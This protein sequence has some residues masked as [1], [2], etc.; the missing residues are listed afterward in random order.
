MKLQHDFDRITSLLGG[1]CLGL[2][3]VVAIELS[4]PH[5]TSDAAV[6]TEAAT[7][8]TQINSLSAYV[9]PTIETFAEVLDRPL[10][11]EGRQLPPEP[12]QQAA[13]EVPLEPLKLTLEGV[14]LTGSSRV[15]LLRDQRDNAMVQV[16]EGTVHDGW[17]LEDIEPD[18]AVFRRDTEITELVLE[19]QTSRFSRQ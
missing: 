11:F 8:L 9:P 4:M 3:A 17:T 10:F 15:A 2:A 12:V 1:T 14:A 19:I 16:A 7:D 13:A 18:K 6:T 5:F